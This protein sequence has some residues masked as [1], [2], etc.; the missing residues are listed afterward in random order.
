[1][2]SPFSAD[3]PANT[4]AER[5][6]IGAVFINDSLTLSQCLARKLH[7]RHFSD[8]HAATA[9]ALACDLYRDRRPVSAENAAELIRDRNGTPAQIAAFAAITGTVPTHLQ[10]AADLVTV[11]E[12]AALRFAI[13]CAGEA[14]EI[15]MSPSGSPSDRLEALLPCL[16]RAQEAG[17]PSEVRTLAVMAEAAAN[18]LESLT[19]AGLPG[20]FPSWDRLAGAIR[21]GEL[22]VIAARPGLGKTSLALQCAAAA[23]HHRQPCV[24]FSL[25]MT[26]EQ[27]CQRLAL[28]ALS[29]STTRPELA[30]WIRSNLLGEKLLTVYDGA[31]SVEQI[32]SRT[33]LHAASPRGLGLV[34]IDYLQ[35][36][37]PP[38]DAK[39]EHRERQV[40][41]ISRFLK[42]LALE[43][44]CPVL[45]LAQL[46]RDV[47]R[48]DRRPRLSDLRESG[49][50]EQDAD[51][52]WFLHAD[53]TGPQMSD[54]DRIKVLLIQ[55][56]RRDGPQGIAMPLDFHRPDVRFTPIC[57]HN[58]D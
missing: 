44:R 38:A 30:G 55:T 57:T 8:P 46:N 33:R 49:A 29:A 21:P 36:V 3:L 31:A 35:L 52:V 7:P 41:A 34:C 6:L 19:V 42:L 18:G 53:T 56:K 32:E 5:R 13:K 23:V 15:G 37:T 24:F 50:I 43:L 47:E 48:D 22:V 9:Y 11:M 14:V 20:P 58:T 17:T 25:E 4:E 26:G 39:R 16:R 28:Q 2:T 51:G 27:L 1:M 54:A 10:A 12:F 45:L 40:A